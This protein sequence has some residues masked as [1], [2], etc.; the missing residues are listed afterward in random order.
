VRTPYLWLKEDAA[1]RWWLTAGFGIA[2]VSCG[3]DTA[4]P[5]EP[6]LS[7][8]QVVTSLE[9]ELLDQDGY[10]LS[11]DGGPGLPL[12]VRDT[13]VV[14][15]VVPGEHTL[16]LSGVAPE[17]RVI[18]QNPRTVTALPVQTTHSLF[19]LICGT[20][21]TGRITVTTFTYGVRPDSYLVQVTNGPSATVGPEDHVTLVSVRAGFDTVTLRLVPS[22]CD[23]ISSNPRVLEVPDG[24]IK[25]TLFK[26]RCPD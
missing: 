15:D 2:A 11:V 19:G 21:G 9:G 3:G 1:M 23:V 7:A 20:P 8:I 5:P 22:V 4:T 6:S 16:E 24:G 12:G 13:V 10:T 17:C 14:L 26:I 25:L 18:G